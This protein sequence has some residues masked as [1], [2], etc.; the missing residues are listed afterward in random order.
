MYNMY[1]IYDTAFDFCI[2]SLL[3][4]NAI[5]CTLCIAIGTSKA[6]TVVSLTKF[7]TF[8]YYAL[9][10]MFGLINFSPSEQS[11]L[12]CARDNISIPSNG[13][14]IL[15]KADALYVEISTEL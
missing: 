5:S 2:Y 12:K 14:L 10:S 4:S 7:R 6:F 1:L 11:N 9:G 13:S 8:D 15:C 3:K